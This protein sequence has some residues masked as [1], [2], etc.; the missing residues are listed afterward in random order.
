MAQSSA[1]ARGIFAFTGQLTKNTFGAF[2]VDT[3]AGTIW[4]YEYDGA[5]RQLKLVAARSFQYDRYL[6]EF[7]TEPKPDVIKGM[8]DDQRQ[9]KMNA[10]GSP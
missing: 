9:A 8:L 3:D 2:M 6:E 1:G 4:C 10:T 5:M 7:D